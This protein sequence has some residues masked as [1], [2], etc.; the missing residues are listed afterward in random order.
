MNKDFD[1]TIKNADLGYQKQP[2][3]KDMNLEIK[4]SQIYTIFGRNGSGKTTLLKSILTGVPLMTGEI[5]IGGKPLKSM[6]NSERAKLMAGVFTSRPHIANMTSLDFILFGR[7]PYTNWMGKISDKDMMRIEKIIDQCG[8]AELKNRKF[9]E[10]SDGEAQKVQIARSLAQDTPIL[11]LDEPSA[12]LDMANKAEIFNLLKQINKQENKTVLFT[13]HDLQFSI[14]LADHFIVVH[15]S[16]VSCMSKDKFISNQ[17]YKDVMPSE[18]LDFD[19]VNF[20][21]K[22]RST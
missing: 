17:V 9:E 8:L 3:I 15:D 13:G 16:E 18:F 11:L 22:Y 2:V 14:Q 21:L 10:L 6:L 4:S 12:H 1:I 5:T 19:P 20:S 7:Y